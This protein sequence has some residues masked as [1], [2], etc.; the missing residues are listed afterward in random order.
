MGK[1]VSK[2]KSTKLQRQKIQ[3]SIK[4]VIYRKITE[5]GKMYKRNYKNK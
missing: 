3:N 5:K 4:N 2:N 1:Y